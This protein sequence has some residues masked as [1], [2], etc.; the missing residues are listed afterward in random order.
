MNFVNIIKII[1]HNMSEVVFLTN[2]NC[3]LDCIYQKEGKC[4]YSKIGLSN[5][6][7]NSECA[8]FIA[9]GKKD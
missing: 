4:S 3:S 7:S 1:V 9:K 5:S 2:I 8:Y 6:I